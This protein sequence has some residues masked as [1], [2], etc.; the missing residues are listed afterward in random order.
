M[1]SP[2]PSPESQAFVSNSTAADTVAEWPIIG[3]DIH[4]LWS[5]A[6]T[7]LE[8]TLNKFEPQLKKF[9]TWLLKS[10]A[11]TAVGVRGF[12]FSPES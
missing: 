3:K 7:N 9:G 11:G 6:A 8:G 2:F 10:I 4:K 1:S 5:D 12:A